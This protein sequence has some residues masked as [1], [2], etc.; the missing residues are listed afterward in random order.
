[1]K[2][3]FKLAFFLVALFP[4]TTFGQGKKEAVDAY[5]SGAQMIKDNPAGA[6]ENLLLSIKISEQLGEEGEET[7]VLAEGLI[8]RTHLGLAMKLYGEKKMF[9]TLEQLEKARETADKYN[10][11]TTKQ[12]AEGIVPKLYNQMGNTEYRANNFEKAIEYYNKAISIKAETP[13]NFLGI[14]L[15][16]EKQNDFEKM[17]EYLKQTIEVANKV[18]DRNKADDAVNK[19]KAYLSR[20]ADE[21]VKANKRDEA[22]IF[23]N[24]WLEFDSNDVLVYRSL[25]LNYCELKDWDNAISN[26]KIVVEKSAATVDLSDIYF[27][28]GVA[29]QGKGNK[30]EACSTFS[31]VSGTLKARADYEMKEVIKCN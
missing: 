18:N 12:R 16:Y 31:K 7:K 14:A 24:R 26:G 28:L 21:S 1:M 29:Y 20:K 11:K 15:S 4:L 17:L 5:N 8:P 10:D 27:Q 9:E 2:Q 23:L 19:A 25:F 6:L 3:F 30:E 22:T 13:E